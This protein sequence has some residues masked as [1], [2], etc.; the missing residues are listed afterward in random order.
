MRSF[1]RRASTSARIQG[2][3]ESCVN[4]ELGAAPQRETVGDDFQPAVVEAIDGQV[5]VSQ[6]GVGSHPCPSF[7]ADPSSGSLKG[8]PTAP[9]VEHDGRQDLSDREWETEGRSKTVRNK[10]EG[11]VSS[12]TPCGEGRK[13]LAGERALLGLQQGEGCRVEA[14]GQA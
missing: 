13:D 3:H 11:A 8:A 2:G 12:G 1:R 4:G 10:C 14:G 6:A 7:R 5:E 9:D